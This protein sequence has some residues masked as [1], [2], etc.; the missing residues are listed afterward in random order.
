MGSEELFR[1]VEFVGRFV[2]PFEGATAPISSVSAF[3]FRSNAK[4]FLKF[5]ANRTGHPLYASFRD[6]I[7]NHNFVG[8][9]ARLSIR[10]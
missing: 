2:E 3:Y 8:I 7:G 6:I 4:F 5:T 1:F 10:Y 9:L